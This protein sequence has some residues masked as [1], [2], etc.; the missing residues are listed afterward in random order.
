MGNSII[1]EED[2]PDVILQKMN[3]ITERIE[4]LATTMEALAA[5]VLRTNEMTEQQLKC[6][7]CLGTGKGYSGHRCIPCGGTG[8]KVFPTT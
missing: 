5:A 1:G 3:E 8:W 6:R 7:S 2:L 4:S